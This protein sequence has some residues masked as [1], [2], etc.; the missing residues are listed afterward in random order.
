MEADGAVEY[1]LSVWIGDVLLG[2]SFPGLDAEDRDFYRDLYLH[3]LSRFHLLQKPIRES[4]VRDIVESVR[5][6][7]KRAVG[8]IK[9]GESAFSNQ[10]CRLKGGEQIWE[11]RGWPSNARH[12]CGL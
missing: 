3:L 7:V 11:G 10:S 12:L 2:V 8:Q 9:T 5:E 4:Q 1:I 6:I